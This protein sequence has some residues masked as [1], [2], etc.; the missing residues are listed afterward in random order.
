MGGSSALSSLCHRRILAPLQPQRWQV[1]PPHLPWVSIKTSCILYHDT[2]WH[3]ASHECSVLRPPENMNMPT[4]FD[5][6]TLFLRNNQRMSWQHVGNCM[7]GEAHCPTTW[8]CLA[9]PLEGILR[10]NIKWYQPCPTSTYAHTH[11]CVQAHMCTMLSPG[12]EDRGPIPLCPGT[13]RDLS[14]RPA[15]L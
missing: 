15:S 11:I 9:H 5:P 8:E 10:S 2:T 12:Q 13:S 14:L 1:Q 7:H 4:S 3:S 6:E